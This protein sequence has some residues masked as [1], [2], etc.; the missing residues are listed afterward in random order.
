MEDGG[1]GEDGQ[2]GAHCSLEAGRTAVPGHTPGLVLWERG[3][4]FAPEYPLHLPVAPG[5]VPK[6]QGGLWMGPETGLVISLGLGEPT[7]LCTLTSSLPA[8][9]ASPLLCAFGR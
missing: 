6:F 8:P 1:A 2:A 4:S 5:V 3:A 7:P 9:P